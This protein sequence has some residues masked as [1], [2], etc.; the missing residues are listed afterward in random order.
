MFGDSSAAIAWLFSPDDHVTYFTVYY[1]TAIFC[2][3]L[4]N[5]LQSFDV[6]DFGQSKAQTTIRGLQG[7]HRYRLHVVARNN[8]GASKRSHLLYFKTSNGDNDVK[9]I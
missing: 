4:G 6:A 1:E 5:D 9:I 3:G 8:A 7:H 2:R